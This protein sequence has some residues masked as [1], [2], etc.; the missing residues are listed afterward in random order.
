AARLAA[1]ASVIAAAAV[2][3]VLPA[4]AAPAILATPAPSAIPTTPATPETPAIAAPAPKSGGDGRKSRRGTPSP[5]GASGSA[6][7]GASAKGSATVA[8]GPEPWEGAPF[9]AEP[10][11]VARAA[12]RFAGQD[13]EPVVV[14]LSEQ[15]YALDE[16][17]RETYTHRLVY[18]ILTSGADG[19]WSTVE[20]SWAPWHQARP[21][22]RARVITPEGVAHSLDPGVLTESGEV[23]DGPDMFGDG[24][25]LRGPL[26]ATGPGVVVE[27]EVTVRDTAP[28]FDSGIV[29]VADVTASVSVH[30]VRIVLEAPAATPLRYVTRLLPASPPREETLAG[31]AGEAGNAA[32]SRRR[33]TF[34]YRD[35]TADDAVEP[36]LPPEVPRSPYLAF[37]TGRSWADVAHRYSEVVDQAIRGADLSP[38]IRAAGGAGAS[39][40]E[41]MNRLLVRLG[42]IRYTGVELGQGGI[43]PRTPAETLRRKFG[44]CKDK[45]VLLIAA[46]RALDI[47]AYAALLNAGDD[48]QDIE[49]ELPGFGGFNHAIVVVPGTPSIWIDPTDRFARAG[50]LPTD[51]QGRLALI[52]SPTATGLTRT[53][54]A[55]AAENRAVKTLEF[56]LADL[57]TAR[58]VETDEYAGAAERDLRSYY[59][60]EDPEALRDAVSDYMRKAYLAK[61]LAAYD[62]GNPLDLSRPFRLRL[63]T[64]DTKR[65]VTNEKGAAVAI[66]RSAL[67]DQLPDDVTG[68][69][70]QDHEKATPARLADYY[71]SRPFTA[72]AIY[73]IAPPPGFAPQPLPANQVRHLGPATLSEDYATGPGGLVSVTLRLDSG[74]RRISAGEFEQL[75]SAAREL[76]A[77]KPIVVQFAQVGEADL[78]AGRLREAIAEFQR[79]AAATPGKALPHCRLARALL[80]GGMGE[81]ARR[82]AE[83]A[84]RLERRS[85]VAWR[86]LAWVLQHDALGR[87]F[88]AG[89][90]RAGALAAYRQAQSLDAE[91]EATG[92][93]LAI[94]LEHDAQGR[95]Y[96]AGADLAAA[97]A[98]YQALR[99]KLKSKAMDDNLLVA[100]LRA[101]RFAEVQALAAEIEE[102]PARNALRLAATAATAGAETAVRDAERRI[103]DPAALVASL[104]AAAQELVAMRRYGEA[105]ALLARAGQQ[106]PDAAAFLTRADALRR[107]RRHEEAPLPAGEPASAVKRF[108]LAALAEPPAV[109]RML[110]LLGR[111]LVA[112]M[113]PAARRELVEAP[114][115]GLRT[116]RPSPQREGLSA[117]VR[118]DLVLAAWRA[119]VAG[120]DKVGYRVEISSAVGESPARSAFFVVPEGGE[121][122]IAGFGDAP[123]TLG[124]EALRRLAAHDV[125]G[126]SRWLDWAKEELQIQATAAA[127]AEAQD[128][129]DAAGAGQE[130]PSVPLL[131]LWSEATVPA[132]PANDEA[133]CAAASLT[134]LAAG[135]ATAASGEATV[136]I[137]RSCRDEAEAAAA[138]GAGARAEALPRRL[139]FEVALAGAYR[140]L[141]RFQDMLATARHL[142]AARPDSAVAFALQARALAG[143]Q[144]WGELGELAERRRQAHPDDAAALRVAA[145]A[146]S[147]RGDLDTAAALLRRVADSG[148]ESAGDLNELA[149]LAL[150]RGR[151]DDQ[152]IE[153]AQRAAALAGYR[154]AAALHTLASLYAEAGK[155]NDAREIL[156][157]SM[158]AAG[159]VEPAPD[160]WY[161]LGRIA[162]EYGAR[163]V[164]NG[165]YARVKKPAHEDQVAMS[166][167]A[168]AQRR[169]KK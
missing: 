41:T 81:A 143:L 4:A 99:A 127:A 72:E 35:L 142:A 117:D 33:L 139:A 73:R 120:D 165:Y 86:T 62:H 108:L 138:A 146:A 10:A 119:A 2:A 125:R 80:A 100:L 45:A 145:Q 11:A 58:A 49:Q 63:E 31:D 39:Q 15:R 3:P 157:E 160:D 1:A 101:G 77:A 149:W 134:A 57:G 20:G 52:A 97:I 85:A 13:G 74:K 27:Q 66:L 7:S 163:D 159:A 88:G 38:L 92:A 154:D 21:E 24:R 124:F 161:V 78:A 76:A 28:F 64:R 60:S 111:G 164:A 5:G 144:R 87:R 51:D 130:A 167:W 115:R 55:E 48:E 150:V 65:A 23:Q 133:R 69:A 103:W 83:S 32:A 40:L 168:L 36:G 44:D 96:A 136:E 123:A 6:A 94:L 137:L 107:A 128:A 70:G 56:F 46:L 22:V 26:P 9:S 34:D 152:A 153:D 121:Y 12:A 42:E 158:Q 151:P 116:T 16:A 90:D 59:V 102:T 79:E 53:P 30:H 68:Q 105:A 106:S 118:Q 129:T 112:G 8:A 93:D 71:F 17:G 18:R 50:E 84:T 126:A 109:D 29:E 43:V 37:S 140:G 156:L 155:P 122:R 25:V 166:C 98:E 61:D 75:R 47:P 147:R 104:D 95:R 135:G 82:E 54:E 148:R 110:A 91:D 89:F 162:E 169:L 132:A 14:L 141:G 19:S 113:T 114:G 67:L 131:A